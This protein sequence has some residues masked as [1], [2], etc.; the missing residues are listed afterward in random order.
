MHY[1]LHT[2]ITITYKSGLFKTEEKAKKALE[3]AKKRIDKHRKEKIL[4]EGI[5]K[6]YNVVDIYR[7]EYYYFE[8]NSYKNS[9][10]M[11]E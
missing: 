5:I 1:D 11:K 8:I 10:F 7:K 2:F 9:I 4:S 6:T 3:I